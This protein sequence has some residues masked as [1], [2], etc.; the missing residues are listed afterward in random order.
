MRLHEVLL[1]QPFYGWVTRPQELLR[2]L[3]ASFS[4]SALAKA[5]RRLK[6]G[7]GKH[8]E[9]RSFVIVAVASG[10][11]TAGLVTLRASPMNRALR[12]LCLFAAELFPPNPRLS[13]F[14]RG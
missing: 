3:S 14:I 11:Q 9:A 13:A 2:G 4:W 6:P 7:A 5:W 1:D 8:A 10:R 12:F